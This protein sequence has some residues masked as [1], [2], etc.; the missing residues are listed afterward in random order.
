[1]RR[2]DVSRAARADLREIWSYIGQDSSRSARRFL[3]AAEKLALKLAEFPELGA[4]FEIDHPELEGMR[5]FP[6]PRF[7]KYLMFYRNREDEIEVVR[8]IHGAR[9]LPAIL[10]SQP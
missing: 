6:I 4:R 7:K 8:V 9:D 10:E 5:V 1:M 3:L 2:I